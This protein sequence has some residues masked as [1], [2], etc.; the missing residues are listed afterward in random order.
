MIT[1]RHV[2]LFFFKCAQENISKFW[3]I[4]LQSASGKLVPYNRTT[5]SLK[6]IPSISSPDIQAL[7]IFQLVIIL[8]KIHL[9]FKVKVL[10]INSTFNNISVISWHLG[11]KDLW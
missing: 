9:G 10:V 11:F 1:G 2:H 4:L 3:Q 7:P 5:G 6:N 8:K